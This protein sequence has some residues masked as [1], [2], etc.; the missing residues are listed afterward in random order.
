MNGDYGACL[1]IEARETRAEEYAGKE[2]N[3]MKNWNKPEV[4]ELDVR[5]TESYKMES[6]SEGGFDSFDF[7]QFGGKS[8]F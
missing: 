1:I 7:N 8:G 2:E 4:E 6:T 3:T 5:C